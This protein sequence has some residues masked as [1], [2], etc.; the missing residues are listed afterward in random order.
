MNTITNTVSSQL[1]GYTGPSNGVPLT[2][3]QQQESLLTAITATP[4]SVLD[5]ISTQ[6]AGQNISLS[7]LLAANTPAGL[8]K[9]TFSATDSFESTLSLL[10]A[11]YKSA[12]DITA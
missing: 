11:T 4:A 10:G 2:A 8:L 6:S 9:Q 1:L 12:L 7:A 5:S 3:K